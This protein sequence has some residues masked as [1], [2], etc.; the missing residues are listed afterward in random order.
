MAAFE[1]GTYWGFIAKHA[2]LCDYHQWGAR[3]FSPMAKAVAT[4]TVSGNQTKAETLRQA[5]WL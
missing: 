1:S 3:I 4:C 5:R 2:V